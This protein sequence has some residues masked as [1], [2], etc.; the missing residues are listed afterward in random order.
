MEAG[1][2]PQGLDKLR[3]YQEQT[4]KLGGREFDHTAHRPMT[5]TGAGSGDGKTI[6]WK[7][8]T[9]QLGF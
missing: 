8:A 7:L 2:L 5:G 1:T 6:G 4:R 9:G 3:R